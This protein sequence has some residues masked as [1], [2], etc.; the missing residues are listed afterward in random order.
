MQLCLVVLWV[1]RLERVTPPRQLGHILAWLDAMMDGWIRTGTV[2]TFDMQLY[3]L[4]GL[5]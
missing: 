4:A 5:V 2:R 3:R 1:G